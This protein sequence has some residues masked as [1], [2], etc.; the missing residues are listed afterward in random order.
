[1]QEEE[2]QYII[3]DPVGDLKYLDQQ[4]ARS[5]QQT[6]FGTQGLVGLDLV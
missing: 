1:M 3:G 2:E 5:T 4:L 6:K